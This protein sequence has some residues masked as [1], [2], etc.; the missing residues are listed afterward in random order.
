MS[1][2]MLSTTFHMYIMLSHSYFNR[3]NVGLPGLAKY[4]KD[5]S[6]EE[7]E[8]A[9]LLM[10]LQVIFFEDTLSGCCVHSEHCCVSV[11]CWKVLL[12]PG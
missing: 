10:N 9:Q 5:S 8:H 12:L 6:D 7:R 3:D 2:S 1:R 4:F 11:S